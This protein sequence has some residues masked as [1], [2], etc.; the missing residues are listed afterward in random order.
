MRA[1][2]DAKELLRKNLEANHIAEHKA[3]MAERRK[4]FEQR[5]KFVWTP[6]PTGVSLVWV[7]TTTAAKGQELLTAFFEQTLI[8]DVEQNDV[9]ILRNWL[10][11]DGKDISTDL[12]H[13]DHFHRIRGVTSDIRVAEVIEEAAKHGLGTDQIPFDL[14]ITPLITGSP[15]YLEWVQLQTMKKEPEIAFFNKEPEAEIKGLDNVVG[16]FD[17]I[18][19]AKHSESEL[20]KETKTE[21]TKAKGAAKN[22]AVQLKDEQ[23][24]EEEESGE[25]EVQENEEGE[26]NEE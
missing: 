21:I 10:N 17:Y 7:T 22:A 23:E 6:G 14:I 11:Y 2:H 26:K 4:K 13:M 19:D 1:A 12:K 24:D 5:F 15:D 18:P 3:L 16:E 9:N 8:A 20:V 25:E